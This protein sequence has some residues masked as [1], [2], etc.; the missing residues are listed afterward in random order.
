MSVRTLEPTLS[1][2]PT[3]V[4]STASDVTADLKLALRRLA[5]AVVVITV[6]HEG[7]R[8]A[9]AATAVDALSMEPPSLLA[10]V[11]RS[12][13]IYRAMTEA[14]HFAINILAREHE[15]LSH[16]CGGLSKGEERFAM[17]AWEDDGAAP[18]LA[19]AQAAII[20]RADARFDYGT[21]SIFVGIAEQVRTHGIVNPLVYVDGRYTGSVL[22]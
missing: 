12:A 20:C 18:V 8:F 7:Q 11:N 2:A 13:S 22:D 9:M 14:S 1:T 15:N 19:D 10:C 5:K 16:H 4:E 17:G 21:H 6:R 3:N